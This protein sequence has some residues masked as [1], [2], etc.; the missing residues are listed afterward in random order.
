MHR[1]LLS[2]L[3]IL[4]PL[5]TLHA[6]DR[7]TEEKLVNLLNEFLYGAS[8]NDAEVHDRFWADDLIYTSSA[9]ERY[10]KDAIMRSLE[11]T[12]EVDAPELIY[13]A[14][15]IQINIYDNTAI[16]A[17]KLVGTSPDEV[18]KFLNSGTFLK[19]DGK[20]QVVNWQATRMAE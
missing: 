18:L 15:E 7:S 17:F 19:R 12:E 3:I 1:L 9:G 13:T 14:E 8:V 5:C 10:G 4:F 20:W 2:L 16:V 11:D 6:N